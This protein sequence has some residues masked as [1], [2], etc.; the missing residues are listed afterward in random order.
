MSS[1]TGIRGFFV[2]LFQWDRDWETRVLMFSLVLGFV[3]ALVGAADALLVRLQETSFAL[4][5]NLLTTPWDYYAAL[6]LHASR[7]LFGFA[8][9]VEFGVFVF[10]VAKFLKRPY[11][12][13]YTVWASL[14]LLN[15][16]IFLFEGPVPPNLSFVDSYFSATGWDSL[17]ALGV[18][19]Y[20][21]YVV[22][23][24][25][26]WGWLL[27]EI[28]TFLWGFWI[29]YNLAKN[30]A[31]GGLN[32]VLWFVLA[33]T[34][35]FV[36]GYAFTFVSTNWEMLATYSLLPLNS[37]YNQFVF[38]FY[39]H[40]VVYMLFLPAVTALYFMVPILV[41]RG[42]YSDKLAKSSALLYL[43]F[44]NVVPIHHLYNAVFPWW[45]N[46]IQEVMTYGVVVPSIM[47]FFNLWATT[48]GVKDFRWSV[49][50]AFAALSFAGAIAAGVTGVANATVS[51]DEIVHN[52]MWIVGH[53]H[54]MILL[55]IVPGAFA[56][57]YAI[58]PIATMKSWPSRRLGWLHFY[59]TLVGG[60]G[61]ILFMDDIG[62]VGILRRSMTFP[63]IPEVVFG[64]AATTVFAVVFGI[65]Q[66]FFALNL[67]GMIFRAPP[68]HVEKSDLVSLVH[69]AVSTVAP[70]GY[71]PPA[72]ASRRVDERLKRRAE[73]TWSAVGIVLLALTVV[74]TLP[75]EVNVGGALS[76]VPPAYLADPPS[77][78][79]VR[80]VAHEYFWSFTESGVYNTTSVNYFIT[81]PGERILFNG[82]TAKGNALANLFIPLYTDHVVNQELYQGYDSYAWITAPTTPGVYGFMNGEYN[83]PFYTYMGGEMIVMPEGGI[84]TSTEL[85]SYSA[86]LASDPY[87]PALV[88]SS[89]PSFVMTGY[90]M[91]NDTN[92]APTVV[93]Q[94]GT[95][96]TLNFYV[97]AENLA[98]YA[99]YMFN[100]TGRNTLA[101]V[102]SYLSL[103]GNT[104]PYSLQ[105]VRIAPD[106]STSVVTQA[107]L[108]VG[109]NNVLRFTV[110]PGVY[111]YGILSPV[112]YAFDP[113]GM[114]GPFLGEDSGEI[115]ALWGAVLVVDGGSQ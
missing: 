45:I 53:F 21:Q 22:S 23:P 79:G 97:S 44:S 5:G 17:A 72:P 78:L 85:R 9:Q 25:W 115:T 55:M 2:S 90:G 38:W 37:V 34:L 28:S 99:N 110:Q 74:A 70:P 86:S 1:R 32:Y 18:H 89:S 8:Q 27:L 33:T 73:L 93:A 6:T 101:Q 4:S 30:R 94:N 109:A 19:G 52:G 76:N 96:L 65:G 106:G 80:V 35:L 63:R 75:Y 102:S 13:N 3:W 16:S 81:P 77:V 46:L 82:T 47:T 68:L 41:N 14:I 98:Q 7:M 69:S 11:R 54:A 66:L 114:S 67:V 58:L 26:W 50:A 36:M 40:S 59:F 29:V 57:L 15:A 108:R 83:G 10:V 39:G 64:E 113:Y 84:L 71:S 112:S 48:K 20:S 91:W 103:H 61:T 105:V 24:L 51:F 104:L 95:I 49:P 100:L 92:P 12:A 60:S 107:A 42:I 43:A 31:E 88:F 62:L 56:L 87:T 111:L